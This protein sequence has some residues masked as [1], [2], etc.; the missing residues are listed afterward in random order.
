VA[1]RRVR[2]WLA[3]ALVVALAIPAA[4]AVERIPFRPSPT[5]P[6][7]VEEGALS[8]ACARSVEELRDFFAGEGLPFRPD[9]V[10][11]SGGRHCHVLYRP[12]VPGFRAS[13]DDDPVRGI[14]FDSDALLF[15]ATTRN[16]GE[17]V[18]A[19]REILTHVSRPLDVRVLM[20]GV[21]D[22]IVAKA[23]ARSYG[24]T[25]HRVR[26][27][28]REVARS[29]WWV[30]DYLKSGTAA[31]SPRLLVPRHIFEG[32]PETAPPFDPLLARL[33]REDGGA[34]SRL[35]WEGGDLQFTRDPRD[36][37]R[38]LLYHGEFVKPYWGD[39]LTRDEYAYV[40][41]LEFGADEEMDLGGLAPHVDYLACF[42]PQ[43]KTV[44]VS[45]PRTGDL[46]VARAAVSTLRERLPD[47]PAVLVELEH[48]LSSPHPDR[49][50][51][52]DL[53]AR[54]RH[55]QKS[56]DFEIDPT[57]ADRMSALVD[58][59]CPDRTD[60]FSPSRRL[61]LLE[62]DPATF[63]E[64]VHSV[65]L[66]RDEQAIVTAHLDLVESQLDPVPED[67]RRLTRKRIAAL[68]D[69]G[70]RVVEA[71]AFRVDLTRPRDWPGIS[72]VNA[73][74][75]DRQVFVP[76]FGLGEPEDRI[77]RELGAQLPGGYSVIPVLA[78]RVL[79]RNGG[80][81]CLVGLVRQAPD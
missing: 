67:V 52:A 47:E 22:E 12:S 57:L 17:P 75:I 27:V 20:H 26:A 71:P 70:F 61:R 69:R 59:A 40:L 1:P 81:H 66:A 5:W 19:M 44:L 64:W 51:V 49:R 28:E 34:R 4:A 31:G 43:A 23:I 74:V 35:S 65:Q 2:A 33:A 21:S 48:V 15:L 79:I 72:Y 46:D 30:Q 58:A 50:H 68:R 76:R 18:G 39:A 80:L 63:E 54:A 29:L 78:E 60:C 45:V 42:L 55:E 37:S 16:R 25:P 62:A 14:L 24:D 3:A 38:L 11:T 53:V 7:A 32:R 77:L 73:V 41:G 8:L 9:L 6:D 10:R 56:W 13:P 36:P